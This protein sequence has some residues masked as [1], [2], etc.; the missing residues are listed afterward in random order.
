MKSSARLPAARDVPP[1]RRADLMK[2]IMMA[3]S[4]KKPEVAAKSGGFTGWVEGSYTTGMSFSK[5]LSMAAMNMPFTFLEAIGIP[6]DKTAGL[7]GFNE[8][9]VG[10]VY[11]GTDYV[12]RKAGGAVVAPFEFFGG[13]VKKLTGG[14][15]EEK[16]AEKPKAKKV[17][18]KKAK[19]KA[20]GTKKAPAKKKAP[21]KVAAAVKAEPETKKAA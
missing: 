20:V 10:S 6:E 1:G 8:K 13:L 2:E 18:H 4:E 16:P 15:A 5:K 17:E 11:G 7:K 9:F 3:K 21:P 12:A 19:P 14:K